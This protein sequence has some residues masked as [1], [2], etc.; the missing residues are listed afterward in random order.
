[1][2]KSV[3]TLILFILLSG[4]LT[5]EINT[6]SVKAQ[7]DLL[8]EVDVDKTVITVGDNTDITLTL[9]NVGTDNITIIYGPPLFDAWYCTFEGCF[10]WSDGKYFIQIVL[11]LTLKPG[12]NHSETLRWNLYQYR[13]GKYH[14][15]KPGIYYLVG[16]C[17]FAET[18][19]P[20]YI[21]V[22]VV[23]PK[24]LV[25]ET[26][27]D[28]YTL[29]EAVNFK[30]TNISNRTVHFGGYPFCVVCKWP[31]WERVAPQFFYYLAWS[32]DPG[33]SESWTWNSAETGLYVAK[34]IY[35]YNCTVFFKIKS[36]VDMLKSDIN[37]DGKVDIEDICIVAYAF[38]SY[39]GH[40]R[41]NPFTDINLDY[42]IN[43]LDLC[44]IAKDY[45][46]TV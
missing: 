33:Q 25:L 37:S 45:G 2:K 21:A 41:W 42:K 16:S 3:S 4:M 46:K 31:S 22:R 18:V 32:L 7:D 19:I 24:P 39:P 14:P 30:L 28:I 27:K 36:I 8:L 29:G 40:S 34:D 9:V 11:G 44:K 20:P 12:E 38:A 26:K 13:D 6:C 1:M 17:R 23:E 15:P 43:I 35:G 5:L 10:R